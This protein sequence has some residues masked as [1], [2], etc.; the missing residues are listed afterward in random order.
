[1]ALAKLSRGSV[2]FQLNRRRNGR[3]ALIVLAEPLAVSMCILLYEMILL[4]A[5]M[6][7][8]FALSAA[9]STRGASG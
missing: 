3:P 4:A 9:W 7:P 5:E 1:M 6:A 2:A 8:P